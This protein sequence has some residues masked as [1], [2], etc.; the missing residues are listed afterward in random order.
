MAG[1]KDERT[2]SPKR[3]ELRGQK[4]QPEA[5]RVPEECRLV[6]AVNKS[7]LLPPQVTKQRLEVSNPLLP[8]TAPQHLPFASAFA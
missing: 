1:Q 5:E 4:W 7:D 8:Y 3:E 2:Q 6:I